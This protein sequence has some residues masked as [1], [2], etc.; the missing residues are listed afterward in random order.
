MGTTPY[1]RSL[2]Q[3]HELVRPWQLET[4]DFISLLEWHGFD[5]SELSEE[6]TE[7]F[8]PMGGGFGAYL[9]R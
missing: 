3:F 5:Q 7:N 8:G 1:F 6:D 2:E 4:E 9:V